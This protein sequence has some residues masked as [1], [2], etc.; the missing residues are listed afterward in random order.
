[1]IFPIITARAQEKVTTAEELLVQYKNSRSDTSKVHLLLLLGEHYLFKPGG[2]LQNLDSAYLFATRAK[3]LSDS[4]HSTSWL[5][6]SLSL[7]GKY[8]FAM[9]DLSRGKDC[10]LR[11]IGDYHRSGDK[12]KEASWWSE[13][14]N[15]I[16]DT[17]S[18]YGEEIFFLERALSLYRQ[19]GNKAGEAGVLEDMAYIHEV[20]NDLKLAEGEL[21]EA[22]GIRQ[23]LDNKNLFRDYYLLTRIN[24]T[25]GNYQKTMYYALAA[26]RNMEVS[27]DKNEAGVIYYELGD[28]YGALGDV[29]QSIKW[30]K[31]S[32]EQLAAFR[33]QYIFPVCSRIVHGL[34]QKGSVGEAFSFLEKFNRD[35]PALNLVD[36]ELMAQAK[37]DCYRT[38]GKYSLA[39]SNYLKMVAWDKEE[40]AHFDN[41]IEGRDMERMIVGAEAYYTIGSFYVERG[42]FKLAGPYLREALATRSFAPTLS[43]QRDIH[44]MLAKVDSA[45]GDFRSSITH[46]EK[47]RILNDSLFN[48]TT[49]KQIEELKIMYET[50]EKDSDITHKDQVIKILT[51]RGE[52][53]QSALREERIARNAIFFAAILLASLLGLSYNRYRLKQRNN[54]KLQLQ[55]QEINAANTSLRDLL[56]EKDGLIG[57]KEWLLKEV[58][59]RV[60][61]NLQIMISLLNT[62]SKFLNSE[63]AI[64]AIRESRHRMEAMSLIH[65]KLYQSENSKTVKMQTYVREL[66]SHLEA[67]CDLK[68]PIRFDLRVEGI[69]LDISQAI[70]IGLI[71]NEAITNAMKYA[72]KGR[73]DGVIIISM[74]K[75][76]DDDIEMEITDNGRGLP[77]DFDLRSS[78][79]M[80]MR[81]MRG[82]ARQIEACMTLTNEGGLTIKVVL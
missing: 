54:K 45:A 8:Y 25:I 57:E 53:Q 15:A 7:T 32:L 3:N 38:L 29:E 9:G 65:Q 51:S 4:L 80:G 68:E 13:L 61:N 52:L 49:S 58:H 66:V 11:M 1:M 34:L 36:R 82:L 22:I 20:H 21:L 18:T 59:H 33:H 6:Q 46:F 10:F 67:S 56:R 41:E 72:F 16:P 37:G 24:L 73:A 78:N 43:R 81:L 62:Q 14:E 64:A 60:K 50:E 76:T 71:L 44:W 2:V 47:Q 74:K 69:E 26:L 39:E 55:Q 79:T 31:A 30:Y 19:T 77:E 5:Y 23:S 17:D 12:N 63:E 42:K 28:A 27:G 48:V 70:P 75:G 40:Q 35:N